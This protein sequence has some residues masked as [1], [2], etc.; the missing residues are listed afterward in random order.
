MDVAEAEQRPVKGA[1]ATI[2]SA[3]AGIAIIEQGLV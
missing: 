3:Q 1:A 2:K